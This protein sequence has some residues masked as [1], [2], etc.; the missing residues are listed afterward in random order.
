[1]VTVSL[2]DSN[3]S[4]QNVK[5]KNG[6]IQ[7]ALLINTHANNFNEFMLVYI[8]QSRCQACKLFDNIFYEVASATSDVA[9]G[10]ID[11]K[12]GDPII[13]K[14]KI[15]NITNIVTPFLILFRNRIA[16]S[17][18]NSSKINSADDLSRHLSRII[19]KI[20]PS[21][22][23]DSGI[24]YTQNHPKSFN[25]FPMNYGGINPMDR[26]LSVPMAANMGNSESFMTSAYNRPEE[27]ITRNN[28]F[29]QRNTRQILTTNIYDEDNDLRLDE[30]DFGT[31]IARDKPWLRDYKSSTF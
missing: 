1:M 13:E 9:F 29:A 10:V 6:D 7:K 24:S 5:R 23:L 11:I 28:N 3:F 17:A 2:N 8:K 25:T 21:K 12:P 20:N 14:L 15:A 26:N 19:S 30:F 18:F 16:M 22:S 4:V 31:F 27:K